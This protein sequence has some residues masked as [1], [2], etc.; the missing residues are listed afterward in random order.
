MANVTSNFAAVS[1][2]VFGLTLALSPRRRTAGGKYLGDEYADTVGE[3]V[4]YRTAD[5]QEGPEGKPLPP[6]NAA[7]KRRK[8]RQ[9]HDP[10]I[11]IRTHEM[12]D[13]RQVRG[14][15]TFGQNYLVMAAGL[16]AETQQ[17]VEWASKGSRKQNRPARRFYE[18]GR[19]GE[20]AV[21]TLANESLRSAVLE[22]RRS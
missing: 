4:R 12:L 3:A 19:D 18:L 9:G 16:D 13:A 14:R 21:K 10:R 7:Y 5:R 6:L 11:L 2:A 1:R 17:K 15:V 22:A 8:V 20:Q